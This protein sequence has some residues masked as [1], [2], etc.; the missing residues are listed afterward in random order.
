MKKIGIWLDMDKAYIVTIEDTTETLVK[1]DS[2]V[3]HFHEQ[4]NFGKRIKRNPLN[5]IMESNLLEREKQ[6]L[7]AFFKDIV[8]HINDTDALV[9]FGPAEAYEKFS[10]ELHEN[11]KQLSAK[12][13]GVKRADS[14]TDNQVKAWVRNFYKKE[15]T[16]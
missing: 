14:M 6:Q 12:V 13:K 4:G 15:L 3:E 2:N 10:R 9:I 11:Y 5:V 8:A 16:I 1:I 7:K